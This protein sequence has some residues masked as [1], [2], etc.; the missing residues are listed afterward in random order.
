MTLIE[1]ALAAARDKKLKPVSKTIDEE[2]E[3]AL[4]W[5]EGKVTSYQA[6]VAI[7]V[8]ESNGYSNRL[9]SFMATRLREGLRRNVIVRR[10]TK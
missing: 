5:A 2:I 4:A 7:G 10:R 9:Y 8:E 6:R 1:K 3:L